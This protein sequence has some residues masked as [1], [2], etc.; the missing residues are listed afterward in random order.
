LYNV[1]AVISSKNGSFFFWLL[2]ECVG[3]AA[4][5]RL[6]DAGHRLH[7][8]HYK[9]PDASTVSIAILATQ[10][11]LVFSALFPLRAAIAAWLTNEFRWW[12]VLLIFLLLSG[13]SAALSPR[14]NFYA[15][16]I[17]FASFIQLVHLG[18]IA[19]IVRRFSASWR[20]PQWNAPYVPAGFVLVI[21]CLLNLL[22]Y[23][24]HPHITDEV[25]YW[26]QARFFSHGFLKLP[27]PPVPAAFDIYMMRVDGASWYP[28]TPPGWPFVLALGMRLGA[29]WLINPAFAAGNVLMAYAVLRRM[30]DQRLASY[31]AW[32][33]AVS[34]WFIF[35]AMSFMNHMLTLFCLLTAAWA[36]LKSRE[37]R[38]MFWS[39]VAGISAGYCC[40]IRPLDGVLVVTAIGAMVVLDN[41]K[42]KTVFG[43]GIAA[44][45]TV[46]S[47]FLWNHQF[48]ENGFHFPINAYLDEHFGEN[49]NA[50]GFGPDRGMGWQIDPY[51]GHNARDGVLNALLNTFSI[52]IDLFGWS[53]GSL[54]L[55]AAF[56]FRGKLNKK[57]W[58][59]LSLVLAVFVA[60]FFYYFSGGPDFGARYWFLMIVPLVVFTARWIMAHPQARIAAIILSALALILFV[61]WRTV[62]KYHHYWGMRPDMLALS[63][64]YSFGTSLVL[65]RG[66]SHPDYA[67]AAIYNPLDLNA[68]QPI[69]AWDRD[70]ETT[71]KLLEHYADRPVWIFNGPTI[72]GDGYQ[73]VE[74]P[75][76]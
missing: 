28:A 14:W 4:T 67:S 34:P 30:Y 19:L 22:S 12:Q 18:N 71:K 21:A 41:R 64:Q 57:D 23:Q 36:I 62:D 27:A 1:P 10:T 35:L 3:Q 72:T 25:I 39:F 47:L 73:L 54:L 63:K 58:M 7:Y 68:A 74:R 52:N 38:R 44:T 8:Q 16:E 70:P 53:C 43:F 59:L 66:E 9:L 2:L 6:I 56:L 42:W 40:W 65:I 61:P 11:I 48:T 24:N 49:S 50:Y 37:D 26:M 5:L 17:L 29:P 51:P 75:D 69:Y 32:L 15:L 31:S 55:A 33:L 76:E 20:F 60:Y 46:G 45:M 13:S